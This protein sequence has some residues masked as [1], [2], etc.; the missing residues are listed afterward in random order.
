ML[1]RRLDVL[2]HC[3]GGLDVRDDSGALL[4][5]SAWS[6]RKRLKTCAR[7]RPG[8]IETCDQERI[9]KVLARDPQPRGKVPC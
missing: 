8:A 6:R 2:V 7:V 5:S 4:A 3:R 1:R 9:S